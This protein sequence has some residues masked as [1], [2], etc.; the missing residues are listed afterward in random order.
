MKE[1]ILSIGRS[2]NQQ[3]GRCYKDVV[4]SCQRVEMNFN[5]SAS[6]SHFQ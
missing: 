1:G 4:M 3:S 6:E 2:R 5:V